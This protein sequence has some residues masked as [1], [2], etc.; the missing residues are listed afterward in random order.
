MSS[1]DT[2]SK[3]QLHITSKQY[4]ILFLLYRF[5]FLNRIHIQHFLQHKN[6]TRI[7]P[8][9]NDL[10]AKHCITRIYSHQ[11]GDNTKPAVY[12]LAV[13]GRQILKHDEQ[14]NEQGLKRVYREDLRSPQFR[15][16][17]LFTAD[18]Y[19][20]LQELVQTNNG[21]LHF[22]TQTDL[23]EF[24]H[25]LHPLPDV[26]VAL[27]EQN[28]ETNR[29][30][31]EVIEE[32]IP[33]FALRT[34]IRQY[35]EYAQSQQWE[36]ETTHPFPAIML[37]CPNETIQKFLSSFIAK[38]Y[39]EKNIHSPSFFL[40]TKEQVTQQGMLPEIWQKAEAKISPRS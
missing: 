36:T 12:Y 9:L 26:Y 10:T 32:G 40:T 20:A 14:C 35:I 29:Y 24:E 8:W 1:T 16:H 19:F 23:L 28:K 30:F 33:R 34:R 39:E 7:T 38:R 37:I 25:L 3:D 4:E 15:E 22:Y 21:T 17:C 13:G 27:E 2:V 31:F 6:P 18:L 11:F 5:R